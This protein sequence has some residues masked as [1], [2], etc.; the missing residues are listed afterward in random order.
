MRDANNNI[1]WKNSL[2][3]GLTWSG[4]NQIPAQLSDIEMKRH[5]NRLYLLVRGTNNRLYTSYQDGGSDIWSTWTLV[6]N[7]TT[8]SKP[9]LASYFGRLYGGFKGADGKGYVNIAADNWTDNNNKIVRNGVNDSFGMAGYNGR[10]CFIFKDIDF[11]T[12]YCNGDPNLTNEKYAINT[13]SP[14]NFAP[15]LG[16]DFHLVQI[17]VA[18]LGN[19]TNNI[20]FRKLTSYSNVRGYIS[21]MKWNNANVFNSNQ[22][23]EQ[24]VFL[25]NAVGNNYST[26][27]SKANSPFPDCFPATTWTTS[28]LPGAYLDTRFFETGKTMCDSADSGA[29][30]EVSYTLGSGNPEQIKPNLVYVN[31][32][33]TEKEQEISLCLKSLQ[34]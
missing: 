26:Y 13:Y 21:D 27:L 32:F 22:G 17:T 12:Q 2:N 25:S 5:N 15:T 31:N 14:S 8:T 33:E 28:S 4:W 7:Q 3:S 18:N 20:L 6:G 30:G 9:V 11:S 16:A 10:L 24:D 29:N 23:Y 34:I 1:F 19:G